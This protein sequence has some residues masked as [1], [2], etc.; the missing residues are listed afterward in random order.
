MAKV[1]AAP[2]SAQLLGVPK[3]SAAPAIEPPPPA[4]A[5]VADDAPPVEPA[6]VARR[7]VPAQAPPPVEEP[8]LALT[9]RLPVSTHERLREAAFRLRL[10]KQILVD[11]AIL[12]YLEERGF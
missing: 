11:E 12:A 4:A 9:V 6:P 2:L 3:G 5:H 1:P 7:P 10:E 8:R